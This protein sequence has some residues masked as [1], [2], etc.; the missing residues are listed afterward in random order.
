[1]L[2]NWEWIRSAVTAMLRLT[3]FSPGLASSLISSSETI[4][5]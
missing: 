1:M 5:R 2:F 4:H 3:C